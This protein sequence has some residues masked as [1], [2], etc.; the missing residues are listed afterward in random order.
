LI[1]AFDTDQAGIAATRRA[2]EEALNLGFNVKIADMKDAKD[3]DEA[4]RKGISVWRK[5]VEQAPNFAEYFFDKTLANNKITGVEVKREVAK[6]LAP[7][8]LRMSDPV[9]KSH[10]VRKLSRGIDVAEQAIW[11]IINKLSLPKP[12][13]PRNSGEFQADKRK[14]RR[15]IL[16]DQLL[17]ISLT[18]KN[19]AHLKDFAE[20]ELLPENREILALLKNRGFLASKEV[21]KS[22]P[23]LASKLELLL[24]AS[25][26]E[27][28]EQSGK[29]EAD[30][31]RIKAELKK[32]IL[33]ERMQQVSEQ[34]KA[35]ELAHN[36][37]LLA[38]LSEQFT[39]YSQEIRQYDQN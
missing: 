9:T 6:E 26:V 18:T 39:K 14:T 8:I 13:K 1:F 12:Q 28:N 25:Q 23:N 20:D 34:L 22:N 30:L 24:F 32:L 3:P 7:L 29:P 16:E 31:L 5:A 38:K 2:L 19:F 27:A 4:I 35:A 15:Q 33:R 21:E 10:F 37:E 11:D 17:G 36:K